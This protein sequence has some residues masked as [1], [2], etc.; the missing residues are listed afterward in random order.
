[1]GCYKALFPRL[2]LN[3]IFNEDSITMKQNIKR[4]ETVFCG[5]LDQPLF[6]EDH[7]RFEG[8]CNECFYIIVK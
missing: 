6:V 4:V 2:H 5:L 8:F 3:V 7:Y 1:M